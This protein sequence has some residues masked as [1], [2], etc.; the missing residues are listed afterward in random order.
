MYAPLQKSCL[1]MTMRKVL[2]FMTGESDLYYMYRGT[3]LKKT[4]R[5]YRGTSLMKNRHPP[6]D[7]HRTLGIVLL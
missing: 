3:S 5:P 2:H 4:N 6:W 7:P 1:S